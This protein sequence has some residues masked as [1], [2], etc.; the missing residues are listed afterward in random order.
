[1][2]YHCSKD[3]AEAR[4]FCVYYLHL[5]LRIH[6]KHSTQTMLHQRRVVFKTSTHKLTDLHGSWE[7]RQVA[8]FAVLEVSFNC[9]G[10]RGRNVWLALTAGS[11][12]TLSLGHDISTSP[13]DCHQDL[14]VCSSVR[15]ATDGTM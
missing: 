5:Q 8:G 1:M 13:A 9:R 12:H 2:R 4:I 7:I 10:C 11:R 3:L 14:K 15:I 6:S